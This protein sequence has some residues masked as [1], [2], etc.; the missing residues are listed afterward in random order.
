MDDTNGMGRKTVSINPPDT[1]FAPCVPS[2]NLPL[3]PVRLG[4]SRVPQSGPS[5]ASTNVP[6][7]ASRMPSG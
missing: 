5:S 3:R 2:T 7:V 4:R 6:L 1:R